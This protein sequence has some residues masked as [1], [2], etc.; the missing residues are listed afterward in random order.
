MSSS[1][2]SR[3]LP[4]E[5]KMTRSK[6]VCSPAS[7]R[8]QSGKKTTSMKASCS[9]T[10]R[11][12]DLHCGS[13][14]KQKENTSVAS[15][16][17]AHQNLNSSLAGR[18]GAAPIPLRSEKSNTF[19]ER[20]GIPAPVSGLPTLSA[21]R[22]PSAKSGGTSQLQPPSDRAPS[23]NG[24]ARPGSLTQRKGGLQ[25]PSAGQSNLPTYANRSRLVPPKKATQATE[26]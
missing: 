8:S 17:S 12:E 2:L 18:P 23:G 22:K 25:A 24:L 1:Q 13:T 6:S 4:K 10:E 9:R 16:V 11:K 26:R 15:S 20:T 21:I 7:S 19:R 14:V 3:Q 5:E